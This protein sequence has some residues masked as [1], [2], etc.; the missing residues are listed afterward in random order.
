MSK[1]K[2]LICYLYTNFDKTSSFSNFIKNYK[3]F[4]AGYNHDLL[5][6]FKLMNKK[7]IDF[8]EKKILKLK[9][10]TFNDPGSS[11]DWDFG[12]YYRVSK[13]FPNRDIFFMNSH[14]YPVTQNWLKK[15]MFH[16]KKKTII[17][18]SGSFES[19][20]SQVTLKK[21]YSFFSFFKKKIKSKRSFEIF[22]NPHLNTS[23]FMINA[24]DFI[25]YINKKS[26]N[27]KYETWKI[28]SGFNSLTNFFKRKNFKLL[29]VNSDGKK[30]IEKNWMLSETYHYNTQSKCLISDKHSRKYDK[31]NNLERIKS[32]K[33]VWGI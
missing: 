33:I 28:E 19:I 21:P 14:S 32:Q 31:M 7:K 5:I 10:L 1:T 17:A 9:H 18:S 25:K 16:Y 27:S 22:P 20:A 29:V 6:C 13:K 30:F 4:K 24:R 3:K 15:I 2:P 8:F 11:N 23:S 12:S 26:L